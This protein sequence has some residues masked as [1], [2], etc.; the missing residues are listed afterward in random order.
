VKTR[1]PLANCVTIEP[2][3]PSSMAHL[4]AV[5]EVVSGA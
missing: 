5:L 2:D 4:M 1:D 3:K